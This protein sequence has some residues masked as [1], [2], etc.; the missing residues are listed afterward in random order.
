M[1]STGDVAPPFTATAHDGTTVSLNDYRGRMV[2][3]WFYPKADTPG[4]TAEGCG[5]RDQYAEFRRRGIVVLGASFD[6]VEDNTAFAKK[7]NFPFL[8]LCDQD[9]AIGSSYGAAEPGSAFPRRISFL[10]D[11]AGR[12]ARVYD[13]VNARTHPVEVLADFD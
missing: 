7:F 4:C 8:L 11:G 1:L 10:I 2:L 13:P 3:L 9:R 12:I 6:S 5:F